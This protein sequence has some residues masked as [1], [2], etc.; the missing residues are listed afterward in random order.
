M[1]GAVL[2]T[3]PG[4]VLR[5]ATHAPCDPDMPYVSDRA[6]LKVALEK[7]TCPAEGFAACQGDVV[8]RKCLEVAHRGTQSCRRILLKT[9]NSHRS[10]ADKSFN[11]RALDITA[12]DWLVQEGASL[13]SGLTT[14]RSSGMSTGVQ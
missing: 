14:Y 2:R 7:L 12:A 9:R 11:P 6:R 8:T 3:V 4:A 13:P 1:P 5:T 10:Y